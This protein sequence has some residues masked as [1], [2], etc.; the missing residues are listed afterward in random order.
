MDWLGSTGIAACL[1]GISVAVV[2]AAAMIRFV[3]HGSERTKALRFVYGGMAITNVG[4]ALFLLSRPENVLG[5]PLKLALA[6]A[7]VLLGARVGVPAILLRPSDVEH[8]PSE[9]H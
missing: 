6:L 8:G 1:V 5:L 7:F 4:I 9:K 3:H 2:G